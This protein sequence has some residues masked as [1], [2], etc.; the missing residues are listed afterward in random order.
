M[1]L[2][3]NRRRFSVSLIAMATASGLLRADASSELK[4]LTPVP[5][6]EQ[7]PLVDF[8]RPALLQEPKLNLSGT[9]IA[10][11]ITEASDRHLLLVYDLKTQKQEI[12]GGPVGDSDIQDV[13]WLN[14]KRLIFDISVQ[15]LFGVG[16]FAAN[17]GSLNDCYPLL[18]FYGS[19]VVSVPVDDRLRPLVWI[20]HDSFETLHPLGVVSINTDIESREKAVSILAIQTMSNVGVSAARNALENNQRHIEDHYPIPPGLV[21]GYMPDKEG[22]LAYA[23]V[24]EGRSRSLYRLAGD[25]WIRCPVNLDTIW[26]AGPGNEPGQLVGVGGAMNGSPRPLRFLDA[27][28]GALGGVILPDKAYDFTGSLYRD[29]I[30]HEIIGA[31]TQR[32]YPHMVWF[33]DLYG[34]L[35]K[36]LNGF[37]PGVFVRIL[38]SNEAQ[39]LFLVATY[40]DRQPA[41]YSWVDIEKRTAGLIEKAAPWI[42]PKRMQAQQVFKFKTRD[43]HLLDA[44]LTLPAG[45]TVANPPPLVVLS[46]GGP[47]LRDVWGFNGEVQFLA[48]RGY[49]VLQTNYRGSSGYGWMFPAGGEWD[50]LKM[51]YDVADAT[52]AVI[53]K[54]LVD[55]KRVAIMGGSFGGYLAVEG[56]VDDPGLYRCAVTIA[57][58]FDWEDFFAEKK[59][60]FE[61]FG[62]Q[63]FLQMREREGNPA[64]RPDYFEAISPV[65]HIA[66][67]HAPVFVAAGGYDP[68]A[69]IGQSK[70]LLSEL[71]KN[72]IP[73]ES[74]IVATET[75]GMHHVTNEV[76]LYTRIEAFLAANMAPA[77]SP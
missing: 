55:P 75:H 53:A 73:H 70:R 45:A 34:N 13:H 41:I 47:W 61:R 48:S 14:D 30:S 33:N 9:H 38:G 76:E 54:G 36:I 64:L 49:A 3:L 42:D 57:G 44:Y 21:G 68:I 12:I 74:F 56:V 1:S 37:F 35:Q 28:T 16:L 20:S 58:V 69:D 50:F 17:V 22:R 29:P 5:A 8:F 67:V 60:N 72:N 25:Q 43:G 71:E 26:I 31:S 46:H 15:K 59:S 51:H 23:F 7:I 77:Q 2:S 32:D 18:Q 65:R 10:A 6:T 27:A 63:S 24:D 4:R 19:Q 39:N 62:D 11:I 66:K 52:R 40:S